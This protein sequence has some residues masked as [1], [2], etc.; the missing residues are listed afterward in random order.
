MKAHRTLLF[1]LTLALAPAS[2]F[3]NDYISTDPNDWFR[4]TNQQTQQQ[5]VS[6]MQRDLGGWVPCCV[7]PR[8][9][10]AGP[11]LGVIVLVVQC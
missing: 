5:V 8:G 9:D 2:A 3:A 11:Q 4:Y 1:A 7:G 10:E 6:E